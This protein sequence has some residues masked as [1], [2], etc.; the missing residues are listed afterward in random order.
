MKKDGRLHDGIDIGWQTKIPYVIASRDGKVVAT[1]DGH[2][3]YDGQGYGNYVI[4][5]HGDGFE[6]LYGHLASGSLKVKVGDSVT[7]GQVLGTMGASGSST[8]PHLH[9]RMHLNGESVD[10]LDYL[11][12]DNPRPS[13]SGGD[14]SLFDT[15]DFCVHTGKSDP[16]LVLNKSQMQKAINN[17]NWGSQAKSNLKS[18]LDA[19]VGIQSKYKVNGVF[20]MAV[21]MIE[22]GC[23]TGWAAIPSSTYNWYSISGSYNGHSVYT[24]RAWRSYTSF[25]EATYDFGDLIANSSYYFKGGKYTVKTI[26][27]PYCNAEWGEYVNKYM[28]DIYKAAGVS[29]TPTG[30]GGGSSK[31]LKVAEKM[32][33]YFEKNG[34]VYDGVYAQTFEG[35][36]KYKAVVCATYVSWVLQECGYIKDS[37]HYDNCGDEQD[38]FRKYKWTEIKVS[39]GSTNKLRPGDII[40]YCYGSSRWH[41]D[42]YVGNGK[43]L[44]A[45]YTGAISGKH[46]DTW[47]L[48]GTQGTYSHYF[49]YRPKDAGNSSTS[50]SSS[51]F[52]TLLK[53]ANISEST[54]NNK[55]A[56]QLIIVNSSGSSANVTYYEKN[57]S[58]WS[59][60][61]GF[62]CSG[63]VGSNGT[64]SSPKEGKAATPKGLYSVGDAFYQS[65]KPSTKLNTFKIT[66]NTYW[67]DDPNSSY[68]NKK[69]VG[70]NFSSIAS[71][72]E[73]MWEISSYKY[74][75]VINYNT[76]NPVKG[77]GSAIFFHISH[78]SPTAGCVSVSES[79][80]LKYLARLD[81]SKKPYILII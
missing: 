18:S 47:S 40:I 39:D 48:N 15:D 59:Q 65:D 44:N 2:A 37:E 22:S 4:V 54:L 16:C 6:V 64:T 46:Y 51:Q 17:L 68:Y 34:Y 11:D 32:H 73:R 36:K 45:G 43:K 58:S 3:D 78:N 61:S 23:G 80:V 76:S 70:N 29:L 41:T 35:S 74:G 19:F 75:F 56:K 55:G 12:P 30:S 38:I 33:T 81:K 69:Y 42:I 25:S 52:K 53:K 79:M 57:S 28:K 63:Y 21:T 1:E 77:A 9:F 72:G 10:P 7:Y 31:I 5:D 50:T 26:A 24:N 62:T 67:V 49:I 60:L 71:S 14:G 13:T 8:G 66:N 20:A 27:I